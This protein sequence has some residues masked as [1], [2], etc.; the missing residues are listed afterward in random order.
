M[1]VMRPQVG[2]RVITVAHAGVEA[3]SG[4]ARPAVNLLAVFN[5]QPVL[6][7]LLHQGAVFRLFQ[8]ELLQRPDHQ[9]VGP[10]AVRL[11]EGLVRTDH[12]AVLVFR[13]GHEIA[14]DPLPFGA[15]R[16]L[17]DVACIQVQQ[18]DASPAQEREIVIIIRDGILRILRRVQRRQMKFAVITG[19]EQLEV[20]IYTALEHRIESVPGLI[21]DERVVHRIAVL[22]PVEPERPGEVSRIDVEIRSAGAVPSKTLATRGVRDRSAVV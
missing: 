16:V 8:G 13:V 11:L 6:E 4:R 19:L 14:Q 15:L 21:R 20:E 17:Q 22:L 18:R 1:V 2:E 5:S 12:E 7:R 10:V 3:G 9:Q